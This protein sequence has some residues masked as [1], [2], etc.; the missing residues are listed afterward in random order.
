MSR[1]KKEDFDQWLARFIDGRRRIRDSE[2]Q[3]RLTDD[4]LPKKETD[5][6]KSTS[7]NA[8]LGL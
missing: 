7:L 8:P 5:Y 1:L 3:L 6:Q 4:I 2:Y